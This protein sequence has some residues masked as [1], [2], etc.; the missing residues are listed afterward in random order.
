[1]LLKAIFGEKKILKTYFSDSLTAE[2]VLVLQTAG[3][4]QVG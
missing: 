4:S 2:Y 1:M 3:R